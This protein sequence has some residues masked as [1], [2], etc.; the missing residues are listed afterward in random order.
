MIIG[1]HFRLAGAKLKL[2]GQL[3]DLLIDHFRSNIYIECKRPQ[4]EQAIEE[5][6]AKALDQW[7]QRFASD[8]RP[9]SSAGFIAIDISKA[10]TSGSKWLTV[11]RQ[12]DIKPNLSD[13]AER[14]H[15]L[16]ACDYERKGDSR[17]IGVLYHLLVPVRVRKPQGPPLIAALQVDVFPRGVHRIFPVLGD[18]LLKLLARL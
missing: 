15:K 2:G 16:Y 7:R 4:T 3:A 5:N 12:D 8:T 18:E 13:A 17:P 11:E 6:I 1:S 9:D 10:V 14:L